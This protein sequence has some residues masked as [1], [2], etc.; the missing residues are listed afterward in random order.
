[1]FDQ[2]LN[3]GPEGMAALSAPLA[4]VAKWLIIAG[5]AYTLATTGLFFLAGTEEPQAASATA[6]QTEARVRPA[7]NVQAVVNRH[8][9]GIADAPEEVATEAPAVETRLPLELQAV[10][11]ATPDDEREDDASTA[12]IAQRGKGGLLYRV[13]DSVPGNAKLAEVRSDHV[14]LSRAGVR[15]RLN[16]PRLRSQF[17]QDEQDA[18]T[19]APSQA[20][21]VANV[22]YAESEPDQED[23]SRYLEQRSAEIRD[24]PEAV[25]NDLGVESAEGGG[26]RIGSAA[27]SPYLSQTGLQPG[28]VILSVNG[29]PVGD[30]EADRNQLASLLEQ[31]TARIEV[32][33]GS[34]RF[35]VT[36]S[37]K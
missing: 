21:P 24:N 19:I 8:L 7:A 17:T 37:L 32:Q 3:R 22:S 16:F 9:F 6:N 2:V 27:S 14:I 36:T 25:L 15:E 10:F 1:M 35:F 29:R 26:Y 28:D 4:T 31:G 11:V 20:D 12:I 13:G 23:L 34:R 5:I 33:R 30:A 18:A